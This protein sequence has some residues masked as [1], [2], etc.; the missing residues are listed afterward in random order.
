MGIP[1]YYKNIINDYPEIINKS[2]GFKTC[3]NNLL[4][5]LNCA[6]HPCCANKTDEN[7]MF[8]AILQKIEECIQITNVK[9]IVYIAI[10]GPAPRTKMEQQRHRR[11]KSSYEKKI[12]DTNQITPGTD[13]MIRLNHFLKDKISSF[14]IKTILSD[15]NEAGE[16]EHKI[17]DYLDKHINTNEISVVYGLDAD[18]IML[19][20]I[21][22]H[23]IYL[24]RERTEYN[25][26][27]V[28]DPYVYLDV[29]LLKKYVIEKIKDSRIEYK[30][31]DEMILDDYLF[32][33]FLIGND[34]IINS[35]SINI[36]YEGLPLLVTT[37][38]ELQDDY[39]GTFY[40][41]DNKEINIENFYRFIKKLSEKEKHSIDRILKKRDIQQYRNKNKYSEYLEK[42]KSIEDIS[43]Y[44][45]Q[46]FYSQNE[47]EFNNFTN[48]SPL[49]FREN[50][51]IIFKNDN[52]RKKYYIYNTYNTLEYNPSYDMVIEEDI[53]EI[54]QEYFKAIQWTFNYYF[55]K[56]E[57]W[58]WYYRYHYAPLL[59]DFCSY[60]SSLKD[61]P[62]FK[63]DKPY[64]PKEQLKIVLPH[65]DKH[66]MYPFKAPE[67]SLLKS[68]LWECHQILPHEKI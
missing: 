45:Y 26:E 51:N 63:K 23:N 53:H 34:F 9:D 5:D 55:N 50:E 66:Y 2:S 20:M 29:P 36:R 27:N 8:E 32:I 44:K 49:M 24:L 57:S 18:L 40:I 58:R 54:C 31:N 56:C 37:Y 22:K 35:P 3:I 33:C 28:I 48:F 14:K 38:C 42:I 52:Y 13:F 17:M 30:I 11:L 61:K 41:I 1:L 6:I 67:Y 10:D 12:W 43:N 16:G 47:Y 39:S 64:T 59:V 21:R 62:T 4:F 65:Q 7:E 15:S 25:I 60:L 68:Y 46:D 19:S